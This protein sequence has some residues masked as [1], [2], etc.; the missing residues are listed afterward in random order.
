MQHS[1][2]YC[3]QT[4]CRFNEAAEGKF[5][6]A[7]TFRNNVNHHQRMEDIFLHFAL[8][9][10]S[11][12]KYDNMSQNDVIVFNILN[13]IAAYHSGCDLVLLNHSENPL[14]PHTCCRNSYS[15]VCKEGKKKACLLITN[16]KS[17]LFSAHIITHSLRS[18]CNSPPVVTEHYLLRIIL[19]CT[20]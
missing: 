9:R 16:R 20:A 13:G 5:K 17:H 7:N 11:F 1:S 12:A 8:Q 15:E 10:E 19:T 18:L 3:F 2:F 6:C 14:T 4:Q